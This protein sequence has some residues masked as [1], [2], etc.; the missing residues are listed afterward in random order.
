MPFGSNRAMRFV[1][2]PSQSRIRLMSLAYIQTDNIQRHLELD[3]H[4]AI[5]IACSV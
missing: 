2:H 4:A 3:R 1:S 5:A